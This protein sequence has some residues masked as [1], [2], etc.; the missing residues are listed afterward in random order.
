MLNLQSSDIKKDI[1][2]FKARISSA[3]EKLAALPVGYLGHTEHKKREKQCR[4]LQD[5]IRH[6]EQL[7]KYASTGIDLLKQERET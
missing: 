5:D 2:G 1:R 4:D 3:R 6:C 7:I